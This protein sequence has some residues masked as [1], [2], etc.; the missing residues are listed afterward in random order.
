MFTH[1][2]PVSMAPGCFPVTFPHS[3]SGV[4][5]FPNHEE[6]G[7][8][9]WRWELKVNTRGWSVTVTPSLHMWS[10][11]CLAPSLFPLRLLTHCCALCSISI[12][13]NQQ[14]CFHLYVS[15]CMWVKHFHTECA[16]L[17]AR[18][19]L[20]CIGAPLKG[21]WDSCLYTFN[22]VWASASF[23]RISVTD[24][25]NFGHYNKDYNLKKLHKC[26]KRS[27]Q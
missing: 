26:L 21:K 3:G 6:R 22:A 18:G 17:G 12:Y 8:S 23:I 13:Q 2:L 10:P 5:P 16:L 7:E 4:S 11:F 25:P 24:S 15:I 9:K 14:E 19:I 20:S 27:V 1:W